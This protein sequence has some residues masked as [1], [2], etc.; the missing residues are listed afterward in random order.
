MLVSGPAWPVASNTIRAGAFGAVA[1]V[2]DNRRPRKTARRYT[3]WALLSRLPF[4]PSRD[5]GEGGQQR[6]LRDLNPGWGVTTQTALAVRRHR[7]D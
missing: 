6:R 2:L 5:F 1:R 4:L 3:W 7:P